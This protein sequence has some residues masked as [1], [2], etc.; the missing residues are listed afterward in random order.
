MRAD[1]GEHNPQDPQE[2]LLLGDLKLDNVVILAFPTNDFQQEPGTNEEIGETV[3]KLLG[4][5]LYHSPNFFLFKKSPLKTNPVYKL[6][7]KQMPEN[8][9]QHN[10]FKYVIGRDGL[11]LKFYTKK[12]SL[13]EVITELKG[14]FKNMDRLKDLMV[15]GP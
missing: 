4:P 5:E 11:P 9:V 13:L 15:L 8:V 14:E 3:S 10:F 6:L 2:D 12:D 7:T 1:N